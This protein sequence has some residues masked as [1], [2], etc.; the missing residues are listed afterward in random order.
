MTRCEEYLTTGQ[1][2]STGELGVHLEWRSEFHTGIEQID[3]PHKYLFEEVNKFITSP[4]R[5]DHGRMLEIL[6]L[7]ANHTRTYFKTEEDLMTHHDYSFI[8]S[9]L[10]EH[11]RFTENVAALTK[12][13]ET[14][15]SDH[16]HLS[17]RVQLLLIDW[18]TG[19]LAKTDRHMGRFL[20]SAMHPASALKN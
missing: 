12:E 11:K 3:L 13:A 9:H 19:H 16:N 5:N 2:Y 6:T 14:G 10:Q 15:A 8:E 20:S 4:R 1:H 17:F 7:L 18:F